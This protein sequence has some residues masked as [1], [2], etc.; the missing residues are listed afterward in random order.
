MPDLRADLESSL[1]PRFIIQRELGGGGMSRVFVAREVELDR[2]V[3]IKVLPPELAVVNVARFRREMTTAARL[4]HPHIVPLH[5]AGDANGVLYYTMPLVEGETLRARISAGA[6]PV[7]ECLRVMR[8]IAD[9]LAH[10]HAQQ[11][12][13]R[14]IKPE[15]VLLSGGHALVTDFGVA[16]AL[17]ASKET[18]DAT[19]HSTTATAGGLA[20]GTPAYMAPEQAAGD[21]LTDHRADL[22]A[23]GLLGYEMLA[24]RS[25]FPRASVQ[26]MIVAQIAE[27]PR[28]IEELRGDAPPL[29]AALIMRCLE[30]RPDDRPPSAAVVREQLDAM[31]TPSGGAIR[32]GNRPRRI[33]RSLIAAAVALPVIALFGLF[34]KISGRPVLDHDVV[35]V[36]PFTVTGDLGFLRE[37]M[38]DLFAAK[39]TGE[40]GPRAAEPR[41]VLRAWR[42]AGGS[43]SATLTREAALSVAENIGAGQLLDGQVSG[44]SANMVI[45]AR[46]IDVDNGRLRANAQV[47]GPA[48]SLAQMVD[49]LTMQ[50]LAI[51]AGEGSRL[52]SLTSTSLPALRAYLAGQWLYRRGRYQQAATEHDRALREDSTFG[53]AAVALMQSAVWHGD[54]GAYERGSKVAWANRHRLSPRD[55][56]LLIAQVGPLYPRVAPY[57]SMIAAAQRYRDVAS[58]RADAWFM[59]GDQLVHHGWS[60]GNAAAHPQAEVALRQAVSIDS[61]F[62]PALEHLVLLAARRGDTAA[63]RRYAQM[64]LAVD[65][66]GESAQGI[67]WRLAAA[68]GDKRTADPIAGIRDPLPSTSQSIIGWVG[69]E[70]GVNVAES[71]AL[72]R[73][74]GE[75]EVREGQPGSY[76]M[77]H[78]VALVTGRP[79]Q[80]RQFL[81][82][83]ERAF[84]PM[85]REHI[86]AALIADGGVGVADTAA[87][88]LR[89]SVGT[90]RPAGQVG[91]WAGT[92]C[93]VPLWLTI[94]HQDT[95][96]NA[97][98]LLALREL[99]RDTMPISTF[100]ADCAVLLDAVHAVAARAPDAA[101]RVTRADS[102]M[103]TGPAN[104]VEEVGNPVVARLLETMGDKAGA[105]AAIRRR[106]Y[107]L[108]RKPGL[109]TSLRTEGRLASDLGDIAGAMTAY[110]HYLALRSDVEPGI[111]M[112]V[113][114]VRAEL[115]RLERQEA[116]R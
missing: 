56:A 18:A 83:F 84:S 12:V 93:V 79:T 78:D 97:R 48:D 32:A 73:S 77:L 103:K 54:F 100:A 55:H 58:D 61:T 114:D 52:S 14:D 81:T 36:A 17:S 110:R 57:A 37:G 30:K 76:I 16:K 105:L 66:A 9:A 112:D 115:A 88:Q 101:V 38:L 6:L 92:Q 22:Y 19:I 51:G 87:A 82:Q 11:V 109:A 96:L 95:A 24:G 74:I 116:S 34:T 98:A 2:D 108:G 1:R 33:P 4:H 42:A 10:A 80:A 63:T 62:A 3:V 91:Q 47:R 53:L 99:G 41:A 107:F 45:T 111:R 5:A 23:L 40:A 25:A 72:I 49:A 44:T 70:D 39:L 20:I 104:P 35:A 60:T 106:P 94:A 46:L 21:P 86:K 7:D 85:P 67:R 31:R 90:A 59:Y 71:H 69:I 26:E 50:L 28:D 64:Y 113:D 75:R 27:R 15:N 8:D 102:M 13:H 43:D 29:L 68:V 89:A 65:S